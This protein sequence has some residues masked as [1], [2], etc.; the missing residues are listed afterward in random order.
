MFEQLT[1]ITLL[2]TVSVSYAADA[3][4]PTPGSIRGTVQKQRA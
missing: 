2:A 1:L 3:P 4:K